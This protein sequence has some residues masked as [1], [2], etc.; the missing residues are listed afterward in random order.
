MNEKIFL[1]FIT[2]FDLIIMDSECHNS[3]NN[4]PNSK[5]KHEHSWYCRPRGQIMNVFSHAAATF[6]LCLGMGLVNPKKPVELDPV[7]RYGVSWRSIFDNRPFQNMIENFSCSN[8]CSSRY[9]Y[10]DFHIH[11]TLCRFI[12]YDKNWWRWPAWN[13]GANWIWNSHF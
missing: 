12:S 13:S 3:L 1:K 9:A 10:S 6:R 7:L 11:Y 2:S 8:K 5:L 4:E